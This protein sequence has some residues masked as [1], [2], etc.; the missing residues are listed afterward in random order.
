MNIKTIRKRLGRIK[1]IAKQK[2]RLHKLLNPIKNF[3]PQKTKIWVEK[4]N[5]QEFVDV[6]ELKPQFKNACLYLA[7]RF[8]KNILGDYLEFGVSQGTSLSC[9]HNVLNDLELKKIRLFGF[10]SFDGLPEDYI[11]DDNGIWKAGQFRRTIEST[12]QYLNNK[13]IDWERTFLIKGW[14][15]EHL[16]MN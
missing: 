8:G 16:K 12:T 15:S 6:D 11:H 7:E 2:T 9:M 13:G 5:I 4:K 14:F 1:K 3:L 10:D